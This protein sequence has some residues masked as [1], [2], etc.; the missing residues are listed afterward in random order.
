MIPSR[1]TRILPG[2]KS[3][4]TAPCRCHPAAVSA[5]TMSEADRQPVQSFDS[6]TQNTRSR[7]RS[8]GRFAVRSRITSCWRKAKFSVASSTRS[9][10]KD[11]TEEQHQ[12]AN[13]AHFSASEK[14]RHGLETIAATLRASIRN[15]FADNAYGIFGM[16]SWQRIG[17]VYPEQPATGSDKRRP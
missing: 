13:Q 11:A 7:G 14:V 4:W 6:H 16:D 17:R 10:T 12:D 2:F 15:S 1:V 8:R 5:R 3:R 9:T